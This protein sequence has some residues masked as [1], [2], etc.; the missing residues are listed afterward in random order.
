MIKKHGVPLFLLLLLVHCTCIYLGLAQARMV[1]KL[2]L[3]PF[4]LLYLSA[5][6]EGTVHPLAVAGLAFS[7]TGDWLLI[8]PGDLFFLTGMI[9]FM[10]AHVC[11]TVFFARLRISAEKIGDVK[12]GRQA[13]YITGISILLLGAFIFYMLR[14]S[15]GAFTIP[16][17]VYMAVIW[18]MAVTAASILA[19]PA[20]KKSGAS[21]AFV[22][23][24]VL[25]VLSDGIL[26]LNKFLLHN[27]AYDVAVMLLYGL[28][29]LWLVKGFIR[30]TQLTLTHKR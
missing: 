16:V 30:T 5:S 9:A 29:Q 4:L 27:A 18:V 21:N 17:M 6:R 15:L 24:A 8:Y 2:L 13:V 19:R 3:I 26:A 14:N 10:A 22:T 12:P 7:F 23:G 11:Y 20:I 25:F 1:T 28:A